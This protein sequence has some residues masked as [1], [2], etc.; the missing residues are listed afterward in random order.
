M[1]STKFFSQ[2][3][4]LILVSLFTYLCGAAMAEGDPDKKVEPPKIGNFSLGTSQQ[5]GPLVS[6]GQN[7]IDKDQ[8]Q[9]FLFADDFIGIKK[10]NVDLVPS[11]LYGITDN[12]SVYFNYPIALSYKEGDYH[13]S[14]P[15]DMFVQFEYAFY[16]ASNAD[17]SDQ[18]TVLANMTFPTGSPEKNPATGLGS[19]SFLLGGTFMRAY[20]YWFGFVSPGAIL[21]T[22]YH[23]MK[24]GNQFLYQAGIGGNIEGVPNELI[25]A[26]MVELDGQYS[27]K[28]RARGVSDPNSG[29]NVVYLTPSFWLSSQQF[30]L[31]VGAGVAVA[32]HQNGDQKRAKYLLVANLGW[33]F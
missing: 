33:T 22:S 28:S 25:T 32:Q 27:Q 2:G 1:G 5:P 23:G 11:L 17:Y 3:L 15:E 18:A 13:S 26:W 14:G 30:I 24:V 9:F 8:L 6:I 31:Q 10:Y 7:I 4:L 20:P 16:N 29:G 21:T 12:F 19:P